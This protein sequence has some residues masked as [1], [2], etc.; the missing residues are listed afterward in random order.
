MFPESKPPVTI[1]ENHIIFV[2]LRAAGLGAALENSDIY[3]H[4][5]DV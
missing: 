4:I 3:L 2:N 5:S 1:N